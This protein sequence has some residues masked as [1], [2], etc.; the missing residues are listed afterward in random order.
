MRWVNFFHIYQPPQWDE[1]I[2]RQAAAEAYWP[3]V[4]ILER[5]PTVKITLNIAGALTEQL[6]ELGYDDFLSAVRR[7]LER[8][9]IE[10]VGSASY[11]PILPLLPLH[12]VRRQIELQDELHRRV[13]G[14]AYAPKGF[15][16]PE[17]AFQP[18]LEPLLLEMGFQW[19]VLDELAVGDAIGQAS[20]L[21]RY[22]TTSGLGVVIRNRPLSDYL[23]FSARLDDHRSAFE[24]LSSD[25]RSAAWL[26]TAMDGENLGHHRHGVDRLWEFTITHN[27]VTTAT[28]S[29]YYR[30]LTTEMSVKLQASSWS[31]QIWELRSRVPYGLWNHPNNPIHQLQWELTNVIIATVHRSAVDP[32][33]DAARRLLD[34]SLTS[35]KYWWASASPWWDMTIVIRE[36]QKL[37][38]VVAPLTT[39]PTATK[40][41]VARLMSQITKTSERWEKTGLAKRR[42][43]TYLR[44][45]GDVRYM[46]GRQVTA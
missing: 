24:T 17:M 11:H 16:P 18:E 35:D 6:L 38:D 34:R 43:A 5:H 21:K 28:V 19:V 30:Q 4:H 25:A 33:F 46:G 29:E 23:S 31:S 8:G 15:Y 1:D 20:P 3:L 42:Q 44:A 9:Q 13:F 37:A 32:N 2:I 26:V 41:Q 39:V 40:N 36:T 22:R 7:L 10:L 12:E 27:R 45:T 14:P